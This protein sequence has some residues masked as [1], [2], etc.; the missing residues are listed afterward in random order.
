MKKFLIK[1]LTPLELIVQL[2]DVSSIILPST[3]GEMEILPGYKKF[4]FNLDIAILTIRQNNKITKIFISTGIAD[5]SDTTCDILVEYAYNLDELNVQEIRK[6][7]QELYEYS[8]HSSSDQ[9]DHLPRILNVG[10]LNTNISF[11]EKLL[12][13]LGV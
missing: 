4:V 1:C 10:C 5:V 3:N 9:L 7:L 6:K 12:K 11:L 2:S 13:F 8:N